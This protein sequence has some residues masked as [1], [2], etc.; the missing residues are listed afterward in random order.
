MLFLLRTGTAA[1]TN[2]F[3]MMRHA[4]TDITGMFISGDT[5]TGGQ[6]NFQ[7]DDFIPLFICPITFW[8][9]QQFAQPTTIVVGR[10]RWGQADGRVFWV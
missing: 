9:R 8:N 6:L 10:R 3:A 2:R 4:A 1:T 5:V 7:L